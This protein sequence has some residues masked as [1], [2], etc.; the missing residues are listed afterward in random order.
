[1][2]LARELVFTAVRPG[3][4]GGAHRRT[5]ARRLV[6]HRR[7]LEL[8]IA[9]K[10]PTTVIAAT[11]TKSDHEAARERDAVRERVGDRRQPAPA[12]S[13]RSP[14]RR[15]RTGRTRASAAPA[16]GLTR[17]APRP[18]RVSSATGSP[19]SARAT[20]TSAV[21]TRTSS[22]STAAT[23][24]EGRVA[25]DRVPAAV[26][27]D[28]QRDR[29]QR[30][31]EV[32]REAVEVDARRR[33]TACASARARRRSSRAG[34][35]TGSAARP[36]SRPTA[37]ARSAPPRPARRPTIMPH[38]TRVRGHAR[39]QQQP[40]QVDR[41]APDVELAR[42]VL[43]ASCARRSRA[44]CAT[45][46]SSATEG[47]CVRADAVPHLLLGEVEVLEDRVA[48]RPRRRRVRRPPR[49]T[50]RA[51]SPRSAGVRGEAMARQAGVDVAR[52]LGVAPQPG[53]EQA[54]DAGQLAVVRGAGVEVVDRV[55]DLVVGARA[56]AARSPR[57]TI[58]RPES[59]SASAS[60]IRKSSS[61]IP[62][63]RC[64]I[65]VGGG[66]GERHR[67]RRRP[68]RRARARPATSRRSRRGWR[69]RRRCRS[70]ASPGRCART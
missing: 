66:A 27:A 63:S 61:S 60:A 31:G 30:L 29:Q 43:A 12:S 47:L 19:A 57:S 52:H 25:A 26:G 20:I 9:A 15:G 45:A 62:S 42:P 8:R 65:D 54:A 55:E 40:R 68:A 7:R 69:R 32:V 64:R 56:R 48:V 59:T 35:G 4:G 44:G 49:R 34:S 17:A 6:P 41:A 24:P 50:G 1:M 46:R 36:R 5:Q 22:A 38:V 11:G 3:R 58:A 21:S 39:G 14:R 10:C 23:Q 51:S 2:A 28:A 18:P 53:C 37:R 70:A 67:Q 16:R 33:R 13:P